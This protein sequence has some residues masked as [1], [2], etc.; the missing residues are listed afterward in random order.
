MGGDNR[1]NN[2]QNPKDKT[3]VIDRCINCGNHKQ[4]HTQI[5]MEYEGSLKTGHIYWKCY[6]ANK[7]ARVEQFQPQGRPEGP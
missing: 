1:E 4:I 5:T 6:S 2:S 3:P 7:G